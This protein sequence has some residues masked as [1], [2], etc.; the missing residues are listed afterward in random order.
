LDTDLDHVRAH[1][2]LLVRASEW[3]GRSQPRSLL[4]RGEDLKQAEALLVAAQGKEPAPTPVQARY[5]QASRQGTSRRHRITVGAVAVALVVSLVLS[6]VA[7]VQRSQAQQAQ[8]RAEAQASVANSRALAAQALVHMDRDL[9]LAILLSLEAYRTAPTEEAI[10]VL[11]IAAQRSSM[12][13]RMLAGGDPEA[14][15]SQKSRSV[16]AF[17]PDGELIASSDAG[18]GVVTWSTDSGDPVSRPTSGGSASVFA[19]AFSPSGERLAAGGAEGEVIQWDPRTG[20]ELAPRV[21]VDDPVSSLAFSPDGRVLAVGTREGVVSLLRATDGTTL[22]GPTRFRGIGGLTGQFKTISGLA[23]SPDGEDL[24]I[25]VEQ[26]VLFLTAADS[27]SGGRQLETKNAHALWS[28]EFSPDGRSLAAGVLNA[29]NG[30]DGSVL[31][32]DVE[33]LRLLQRFEGHTDQVFDVSF[34]SD[35]RVLASS[36]ADDTVR[37]WDLTTGEQIGEPLLGHSND[38]HALAFDPTGT[39]LVSVGADASVLVWDAGSRLVGGGGPMNVVAFASDGE[40]LISSEPFSY[41]EPIPP[42]P[43]F[44]GGGDVL[45]WDTTTWTRIGSAIHGEYVVG[46]AVGPDGTWFAGGTVDGRVLRWPTD[47]GSTADKRLI[48]VDDVLFG[49]VAVSPD[50]GA[51]VSGGFKDVHLWDAAGGDAL[52]DPLPG[53]GNLAYGLAFSP[54]GKTLATGDWEGRVRA[55]DTATWKP[56]NDPLAEGLQ[57][58]Y[59]VAFDPT[60]TLFAAAGFDGSVIVWDT[61]TWGRVR[62][63]TIDDAIL[64]LAFSPDG[65]VLAVGTEAGELRLVDV[66]TG[67]PVGGP[68]S[69]Q[70]DWVNSVAFSPDGET[71]VA[72]SQDGS[73]ALVPSTAW[74]DDLALLAETLCSVAGRGMTE[75]EWNDF[76]DFK[77][78]D[79]GCPHISD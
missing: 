37:L 67:Q 53:Y 1:T 55:W 26:G 69:G 50:A 35:G 48:P 3:D 56:I 21:D 46:L 77:P 27:L 58:V 76:V 78:Y 20:V 71:L 11:H 40:V 33:S 54:D 44:P 74:T 43:A 34:S 30:V 5:V 70:R 7:L 47:G 2:R 61:S 29:K 66:M 8:A 6:A 60:G 12:I 13:D 73:I 32:W 45:R 17:S 18:G 24:A 41:G 22:A 52:R 14:A 9:D 25:G 79:A 36:S 16:A 19:I 49:M 51:I 4:L 15:F 64:S 10:D 28:P 39:D 57:Q 75:A 63:L 59:A 68:V 42:D 31:L 72:G 38:V 65:S 23:F 62:E